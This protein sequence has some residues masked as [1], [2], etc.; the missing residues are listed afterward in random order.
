MGHA[1][2]ADAGSA[3]G[4]L[5]GSGAVARVCADVRAVRLRAARRQPALQAIGQAGNV[6][7]ARA[8]LALGAVEGQVQT[9]SLEETSRQDRLG[10]AAALA[11]HQP[12]GLQRPHH[13]AALE[14]L[15]R[16]GAQGL[17]VIQ[18]G[19]DFLAQVGH[20]LV[21]L[22]QVGHPLQ[23]SRERLRRRRQ[24]GRAD[25]DLGHEGLE[26]GRQPCRVL[27]VRPGLGAAFDH[28]RVTEQAVEVF[29]LPGAAFGLAFEALDELVQLVNEFLMNRG[30]ALHGRSASRV[31]TC[32]IPGRESCWPRLNP[33]RCGVSCCASASRRR[34]GPTTRARRAAPA[35]GT[36]NS[37]G[38][39]S[40]SAWAAC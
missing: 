13:V 15:A 8:L 29:P 2:E 32:P 20:Q 12:L 14:V 35:T 34:S 16:L 31:N 27:G 7:V 3:F 4:S 18:N 38:R 19:G 23:A 28:V 39:C 10:G 30:R 22:L 6:F 9:Q 26:E 1:T 21:A 25:L 11:A 17:F 40:R 24:D 5:H 33:G 37:V 36:G